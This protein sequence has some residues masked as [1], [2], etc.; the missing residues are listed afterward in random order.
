[1]ANYIV[2]LSSVNVAKAHSIKFIDFELHVLDQ[3]VLDFDARICAGF[4]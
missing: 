4:F 1:M 3:T 2:V